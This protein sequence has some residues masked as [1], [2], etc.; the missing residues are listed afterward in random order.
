MLELFAGTRRMS[1][2]FEKEGFE[3]F[4]IEI[5][6]DF[7]RISLYADIMNLTAEKIINLFGVPTI[8]WA[9]PV[10][11]TYSV[12]AISKHRKKEPNGNLTPQTEFAKHCD[13]MVKHT[14]QLIAELQPKYFFI[15]N[16]MG[17]LR[18]MDFMQGIPRYQIT[19]CQYG[20]SYMK[21][22]DIFT[23]HPAPKFRPPCNKGDSCHESAPRG[24]RTGVQRLRISKDKAKLPLL[25]CEHI[26]K[27]SLE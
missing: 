15:E 13:E 22:T 20:E 27:I 25:L 8:I 26:S 16:P 14:L 7:P 3:T 10:C 24:R 18:K 2:A 1:D 4:S 12:A 23:N 5:D 6:T 9:S 19:Y 17:G 11:T 21:P